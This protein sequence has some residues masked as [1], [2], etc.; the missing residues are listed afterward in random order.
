MSD[1]EVRTA[2][3]GELSGLAPEQRVI[4]GLELIELLNRK[5]LGEIADIRAEAV[6]ELREGGMAV[7]LVAE[8]TN[9][10][11]QA[12]MKMMERGRWSRT[13]RSVKETAS[14]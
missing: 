8:Q 2:V 4:R 1:E 12:I 10:S 3:L 6:V 13:R 11:P 5:L 9:S 14:P 7:E